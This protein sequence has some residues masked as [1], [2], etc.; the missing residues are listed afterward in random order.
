MIILIRLYFKCCLLKMETTVTIKPEPIDKGYEMSGLTLLPNAEV[1]ISL[2]P[3]PPLLSSRPLLVAASRPTLIASSTAMN[4]RP[5]ALNNSLSARTLLPVVIQPQLGASILLHNTLMPQTQTPTIIR[6]Q[7]PPRMIPRNTTVVTPQLTPQINTA[8]KVARMTA[9]TTKYSNGL[10]ILNVAPTSVSQNS[11]ISSTSSNNLM[12]TTSDIIHFSNSGSLMTLTNSLISDQSKATCG[13]V[14]TARIAAGNASQEL[15]CNF[16]HYK[17]EKLTTF[18]NH[19]SIHVFQCNHCTFKSFTRHELIVH[20]KDAHPDFAQELQGFERMSLVNSNSELS[21]PSSTAT[22]REPDNNVTSSGSSLSNNNIDKNSNKQYFTYRIHEDWKGTLILL[23]CELCSFKTLNLGGLMSHSSIHKPYEVNRDESIAVW[24]CFYCRF[25]SRHKKQVVAHINHAHRDQSDG[26]I[27]MRKLVWVKTMPTASVARDGQTDGEGEWLWGCYYCT[28]NSTDRDLV[29]AHENQEH[30]GSKLMITRKKLNPDEK[31][32]WGIPSIPQPQRKDTKSKQEG[33]APHVSSSNNKKNGEEKM[34]DDASNSDRN[35]SRRK[36]LLPKRVVDLNEQPLEGS[37]AKT[38]SKNEDVLPILDETEFV[39]VLVLDHVAADLNVDLSSYIQYDETVKKCVA[40]NYHISG[41]KAIL[42]EHVLQAHIYGDVWK[43]PYCEFKNVRRFGVTRHLKARHRNFSQAILRRK[44]LG[45]EQP[46]ATGKTELH[47]EVVGTVSEEILSEELVSNMIRSHLKKAADQRDK[48]V[49]LSNAVQL[50]EPKV[51]ITGPRSACEKK[52]LRL[53]KK[54][55]SCPYCS[56]CSVFKN[57]MYAHLRSAHPKKRLSVAL[58]VV[59]RRKLKLKD[60]ETCAKAKQLLEFN[61]RIILSRCRSDGR[62][63]SPTDDDAM[64]SLDLSHDTL[65]ALGINV[66]SGLHNSRRHSSRLVS[67]RLQDNVL[68]KTP[69]TRASSVSKGN[70]VASIKKYS[71]SPKTEITKYKCAYCEEAYDQ[72]QS[73]R[74]HLKDSHSEEDPK[75]L[76]PGSGRDNYYCPSLNC[77]FTTLVKKTLDNHL[78]RYPRHGV[79]KLA[80][81]VQNSEN[82]G[83]IIKYHCPSRNCSFSTGVKKTLDN[84]LNI[85]PNH[86]V[87]K[88]DDSKMQN[89]L[90]NSENCD[91]LIKYHCPSRGCTFSS[92]VK[93]TLD[94]HL[95]RYPNHGVLSSADDS[96]TNRDLQNVESVSVANKD[97]DGSGKS[98]PELEDN[99]DD[100]DE[101]WQ[102]GK[103]K[104]LSTARQSAPKRRSSS[105]QMKSQYSTNKKDVGKSVASED[106]S[107]KKLDGKLEEARKETVEKKAEETIAKMVEETIA[108]KSEETIDEKVKETVEKGG[109]ENLR[110][111]VN[112]KVEVK[113]VSRFGCPYCNHYTQDILDIKEHLTSSHTHKECVAID[114]QANKS[115]QL[116]KIYLC[117]LLF[118]NSQFCDSSLYHQHMRSQH[119]DVAPITAARHQAAKNEVNALETGSDESNAA[120]IDDMS[121]KTLAARKALLRNKKQENADKVSKD[122][123]IRI[124]KVMCPQCYSK[125]DSVSAMK[126]HFLT[127]HP[128]C[129]AVCHDVERLTKWKKKYK[130]VFCMTTT[131]SFYCYS[132]GAIENH[133]CNLPSPDVNDLND[134]CLN[135][136]SKEDQVICTAEAICVDNSLIT[137][138]TIDSSRCSNEANSDNVSVD[139]ELSKTIEEIRSIT[140]QNSSYGVSHLL[141]EEENATK[142]HQN[143]VN[144][145]LLEQR[146]R[147]S[148]K[149]LH[150]NEKSNEVEMTDSSNCENS[151]KF[152]CI[153]CNFPST[154]LANMRHHVHTC[155][156]TEVLPSC[157]SIDATNAG[158]EIL[159]FCSNS[160]CKFSTTTKSDALLHSENCEV[161]SNLNAKELAATNIISNGESDDVAKKPAL[162]DVISVESDDKMYQCSF[163]NWITSNENSIERHVKVEHNLTKGGYATLG[164]SV[165]NDG[166]VIQTV[167]VRDKDVLSCSFSKNDAVC[168]SSTNDKSENDN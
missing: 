71:I 133:T 57:F 14:Y 141:N 7:Q 25:A 20:K 83:V 146:K 61:A 9:K 22:S 66:D 28:V 145:D 114:N 59:D 53:A 2:P 72:L 91:V 90:Q 155:H 65:S 137:N 39:A 150:N 92:S 4:T 129:A 167:S 122:A 157:F 164:L 1:A 17:T 132:D 159:Y 63:V 80:N 81:C 35:T 134:S 111:K 16:C 121:V 68:T 148:D 139:S 30:R 163:C 119:P 153:T 13:L 3:P 136:V 144:T 116:S 41:S 138:K 62:D 117:P 160:I 6:S 40:C 78:N 128:N 79:S 69:T 55:W 26:D 156:H 161:V 104:K 34:K 97:D 73:I 124:L 12:S 89:D 47:Y 100:D 24:E 101:S 32:L 168:S 54:A 67:D 115:K 140:S 130:I 103:R 98:G 76:V 8:P 58:K 142:V 70:D 82:D 50:Y 126:S 19:M 96:K 49:L 151:N 125:L 85:Y 52:L 120:E 38:E 15:M 165:N 29:L 105:K 46:L 113:V 36:Q 42:E 123:N 154:E 94:N 75:V 118:C 84:H 102:P 31:L 10:A 44:P 110:E 60:I 18:F 143:E 45:D 11:L 152:L 158:K 86:G 107:E 43:C 77:S 21:L 33:H 127:A 112:D 109:E 88:T 64:S 131:C 87:A 37:V 162:K 95:S 99:S 106:K 5:W 56:R 147:Y 23:E 149:N 108:K 51:K 27:C 93:K 166:K 74:Q 48:E 135:N